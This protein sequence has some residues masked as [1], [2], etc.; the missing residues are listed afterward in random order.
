METPREVFICVGVQNTC[1]VAIFLQTEFDLFY[2]R[3]RIYQIN[4]RRLTHKTTAFVGN[5]VMIGWDLIG[6]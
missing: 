1:C 2:M 4:L 3:N 5:V 6:S